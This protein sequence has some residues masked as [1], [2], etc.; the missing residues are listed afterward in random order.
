MKILNKNNKSWYSVIIS[1]LIIWFLLILTTWVF[2]LVL[3]EL[4]DNK[5]IWDYIKAYAWAESAWELALLKIKQNWY[6]YYDEINDSVNNRSV[7]LS[8][9]PLN[10]SLYTKN[11]DVL[12]SY[13]IWSK[14]ASYD[15]IL[16]ELEYDIIPLFYIDDSWENKVSNI[17][18]SIISWT[19]SDLSWNVIW[20]SAWISWI[21]TNLVWVKKTLSWD[22]FNY[23]R[24]N[25]TSFLSDSE[26]NYLV[27][28]NS[29]NSWNIEYRIRS[30]NSWESFSKPE[31]YIETSAKVWNYKQNLNIK[32]DNTEF[33]NML[34]YSIYSN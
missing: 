22:W 9:F 3:N 10:S 13:D 8:E 30:I 2:N 12:I 26:K 25:L 34:K 28:Q 14:A 20:E 1:L 29:W 18:L 17:D 4:K 33:L 23:S 31:T 19:E 27:L 7:V 15:W 16:E 5:A 6:W 24:Q 11:R 32:L 21:W